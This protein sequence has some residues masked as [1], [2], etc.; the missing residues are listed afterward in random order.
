MT[1]E[2]RTR[3]FALANPTYEPD[4]VTDPESGDP[5]PNPLAG[6]P[7]PF[8]HWLVTIATP[9]MVDGDVVDIAEPI[10]VACD[11]TP[12]AALQAHQAN[13]VSI[14]AVETH[15]NGTVVQVDDAR[16]QN[17]F[18]ASDAWAEVE[19]PSGAHV[20]VTQ[21]QAVFPTVP[22]AGETGDQG[23][24]DESGETTDTSDSS[25]DAGQEA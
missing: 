4:Y 22:P 25:G 24:G 6:E 15:E 5:A 18:A 8:N 21:S 2:T 17:V 16:L 12:D 20:R 19:P 9:T 13:G 7:R 14:H 11:L 3:F 10:V 1:D 23:E